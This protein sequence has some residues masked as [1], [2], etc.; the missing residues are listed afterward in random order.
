RD[1]YLRFLRVRG[2]RSANV[3]RAR[4]S[5]AMFT[6]RLLSLNTNRP[7]FRCGSTD[8]NQLRSWRVETTAWNPTLRGTCLHLQIAVSRLARQ[9]PGLL[10]FA[11]RCLSLFSLPLT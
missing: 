4:I 1:F 8:G 11:L 5:F 3:H 10:F 6:T 7:P 2:L 9:E